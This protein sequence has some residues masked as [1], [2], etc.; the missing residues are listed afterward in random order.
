MILEKFFTDKYDAQTIFLNPDVR[1]GEFKKFVCAQKKEFEK[2]HAANVVL[3]CENYFEFAFNFFAAIFARKNIYLLTDKTRLNQLDFEYI[4]PEAP[5][6]C[7]GG[8]EGDFVSGEIMVNLFTSGS[9]GVPKNIGKTLRNLEIEAKATI[10]EFG[11][12][13]GTVIA[14]T[15]SSAHSYG[16]AFNFILPFYGDFKI[17]QKK[18][19]FPEQFDIQGDYVLIS[20]PSFMEKLAKYDF[21]FEN[22]PKKIFLAGAKLKEEIYD[23]FAKFSDVIDIYGSTETGNIAFKRGGGIFT[24]IRGV[25]VCAAEDGRITVKSDFFPAEKMVLNDIVEKVSEREFVLKKRTDRIVKIQEK[26]IS[27]DEL[28]NN[29]RTHAAVEACHCFVYDEKLCCAVVCNDETKEP[30]EFKRFLAGF[31][32]ILPKKWRILDEIPQTVSGKI[33]GAKLRKIFGSNLSM[34]FVFSR[35][36]SAE[37]AEIEMIFKRNSNFF[38]GHFDGIPVLPGVVQLY[39]ARFFAED[40]F[41]MELPHA[42]AKKIKFSNVMKPDTRV[43]LRLAINE[44]YVEFTYLADDKI[45]SSGIFVK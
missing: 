32:E 42:E 36:C 16:V 17:N 12:Q 11:L 5:C 26:R 41:G 25:E 43:T 6:A 33:D 21:D 45:F 35:K 37:S 1:F 40:V 38:K 13:E 24:T 22:A 34:P 10:D 3:L 30:A 7:E 4:L 15:T 29:L 9:T 44:K 39:Y 19:E 18:I 8:F 20:T 28:E 14:S 2:Q 27:L 23:Y 31:S